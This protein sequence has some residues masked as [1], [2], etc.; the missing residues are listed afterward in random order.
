[1]TAVKQ[2]DTANTDLGCGPSEK[3]TNKDEGTNFDTQTVTVVKVAL[4]V[5]FAALWFSP[6]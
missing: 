4:S 3:C 2:T 5:E 1:M 6:S